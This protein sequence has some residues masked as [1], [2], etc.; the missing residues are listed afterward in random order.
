MFVPNAGNPYRQCSGAGTVGFLASWIRIR[1]FFER[2]RIL[3]LFA[4]KG[5]SK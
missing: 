4:K 3:V 1:K 5:T 2:I